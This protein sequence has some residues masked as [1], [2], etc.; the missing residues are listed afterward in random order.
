M[1]ESIRAQLAPL[2]V[3]FLVSSLQGATE[4]DHLATAR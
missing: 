3:H 4:I 2:L 1:L